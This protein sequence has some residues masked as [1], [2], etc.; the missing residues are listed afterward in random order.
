MGPSPPPAEQNNRH[1][2]VKTYLPATSLANGKDAKATTSG[3]SFLTELFNITASGFAAKKPTCINQISVIENQCIQN[4]SD[5][6]IAVRH[7]FSVRVRN[8]FQSV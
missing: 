7:R 6:E 5:S 3:C 2:P 1:P 8:R 4:P